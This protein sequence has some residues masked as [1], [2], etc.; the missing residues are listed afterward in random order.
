MQMNNLKSKVI[1]SWVFCMLASCNPS[2]NNTMM[3]TPIISVAPTH[4]V[5]TLPSTPSLTRIWTPVPTIT[6]F[7]TQLPDQILGDIFISDYTGSEIEQ[8]KSLIQ[9]KRNKL[10]SFD[11]EISTE[12]KHSGE[13]GILLKY[14]IKSEPTDHDFGGWGIASRVVVDHRPIMDMTNFKV[15]EFWVKGI[16]GG[17][18]FDVTIA[19]EFDQEP[20]VKSSDYV[21]VSSTEWQNVHIPLSD[22]WDTGH[23]QR[24]WYVMFSFY[25]S[26]GTGSICIDEITFAR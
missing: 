8:F 23:S 9:K 7:I 22:F 13:Y 1:I 11:T 24:I 25:A 26:S 20:T 21:T 4:T 5:A 15:L 12:C 10:S 16:S 17:E 2:S 3:Q 6:P 19:H 18:I 14:S